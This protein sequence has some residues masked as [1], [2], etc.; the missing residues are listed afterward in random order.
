LQAL[1][2]HAGAGTRPRAA[3]PRAARARSA[4]TGAG[5]EW[6]PRHRAAPTLACRRP[7]HQAS[8]VPA[9]GWQLAERG[10]PAR[11][12]PAPR[13]LPPAPPRLVASAGPSAGGRSCWAWLRPAPAQDLV[14][15]SVEAPHGIRGHAGRGVGLQ[16]EDAAAVEVLYNVHAGVVEADALD[17]PADGLGDRAR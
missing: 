17:G 15:G 8:A 1:P 3:A 12:V 10:S 11:L 9:R 14:H 6:Q 13:S 4:P 5:G 16:A 2:H 7:G